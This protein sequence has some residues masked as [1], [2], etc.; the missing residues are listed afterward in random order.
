MVD[1]YGVPL[2]EFAKGRSQPDLAELFGV[3]QSAVSQMI[4]STR[5]IRVV[6]DA[7]SRFSAVEIRPVG[8]RRKPKAA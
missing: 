8:S 2:R 4:H 5:D 3:S 7:E 6:V 1:E